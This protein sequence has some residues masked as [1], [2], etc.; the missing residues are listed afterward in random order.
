MQSDRAPSCGS[1]SRPASSYWSQLRVWW[2]FIYYSGSRRLRQLTDPYEGA[3][4]GQG[5]FSYSISVYFTTILLLSGYSYICGIRLEH[6]GTRD[7]GE[8]GRWI[9]VQLTG[10]GLLTIWSTQRTAHPRVVRMRS[11]FQTRH[12]GSSKV[13]LI[14]E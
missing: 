1:I 7:R 14:E 5:T 13:M 9:Q 3:P 10:G 8:P 6:R 2:T 11:T 4:L 12:T